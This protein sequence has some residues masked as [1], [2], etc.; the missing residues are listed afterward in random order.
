[1]LRVERQQH[2]DPHQRQKIDVWRTPDVR[3]RKLPT[4]CTLMAPFFAGSY[5]T[6]TEPDAE[7][8][9][10]LYVAVDELLSMREA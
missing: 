9:L 1:M 4:G 10:G 8:A 5:L 2:E 6:N 7:S 3:R